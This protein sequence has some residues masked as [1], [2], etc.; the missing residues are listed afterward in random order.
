MDARVCEA[1]EEG[2]SQGRRFQECLIPSYSLVVVPMVYQQ[3]CRPGQWR[4]CS[5]ALA[6]HSENQTMQTGGY[7]NF[8]SHGH[9]ILFTSGVNSGLPVE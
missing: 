3:P 4:R 7:L 8:L 6:G 5:G 1:Q 2:R 9:I